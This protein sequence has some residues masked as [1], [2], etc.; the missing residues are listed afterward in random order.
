M[1][2]QVKVIPK[3]PRSEFVEKMADETLKIRLK[4][5]PERGAANEELQGFLA[6][7]CGVAKEQIVLVSGHT[8]QRKLLRLPD[9]A[10]LSWT[11]AQ[12]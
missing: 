12:S 2:L 10:D 4:A 3:S 11:H 9:H 7:A 8:S 1:Y 5:V 6:K